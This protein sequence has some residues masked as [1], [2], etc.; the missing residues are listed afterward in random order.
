MNKGLRTM[1]TLLLLFL[2]AISVFVTFYLFFEARNYYTTSKKL[3]D[4]LI[5]ANEELDNLYAEKSDLELDINSLKTDIE[6]LK[7]D[8]ETLTEKNDNQSMIIDD[9]KRQQRVLD[10]PK[11]IVKAPQSNPP[12]KKKKR[13]PYDIAPSQQ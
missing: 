11:P 8:I 13:I 1:P 3:H 6:T 12:K 9:L 10:K 5:T 7:D 4:E 2:C